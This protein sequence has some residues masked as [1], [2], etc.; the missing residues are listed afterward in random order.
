MSDVI[1]NA[2]IEGAP[3]QEVPREIKQSRAQRTLERVAKQEQSTTKF[4]IGKAGASIAAC[5]LF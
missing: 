4:C 1:P 5:T 2:T 3:K